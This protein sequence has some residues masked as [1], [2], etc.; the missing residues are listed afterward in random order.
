MVSKSYWRRGIGI[1]KGANRE[2]SL[3][4]YQGSFAKKIRL[5]TR[6][7]GRGKAGKAGR[8]V[9]ERVT[10]NNLEPGRFYEGSQVA[11]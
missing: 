3:S 4:S 6:G 7:L 5:E 9:T 1:R 2:N 11:D 10:R 8:D